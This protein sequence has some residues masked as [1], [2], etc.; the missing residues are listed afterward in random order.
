MLHSLELRSPFLDTALVEYVTALPDS[1]KRR[2][3]TT[4]WILRRA[5]RDL[6]PREIQRRAKMGFGIPLGRWFERACAATC[7]ICS[8]LRPVSTNTFAP[9]SC[10]VFWRSTKRGSTTTSTRSGFSSRWSAGCSFSGLVPI[11]GKPPGSARRPRLSLDAVVG[12]SFPL[13]RM[14]S[15]GREYQPEERIPG[16]VYEVVRLIGAGGMGTVYDVEDTTIGK[17]YVLKTLHPQLGAREDLARRMQ[18]EARTLARLNHPNIVEVITAGVPATTF[19][20]RFT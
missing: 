10:S 7:A 4:K 2:G 14:P 1:M 12:G 3:L 16:T 6:V 9:T 5:F 18:K 19:V 20:C 8:P 17:R 15:R 11:D 13:T